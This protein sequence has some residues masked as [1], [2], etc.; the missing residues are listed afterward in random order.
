M[1]KISNHKEG[2]SHLEALEGDV[3]ESK[4]NTDLTKTKF[5]WNYSINLEDG[6][7]ELIKENF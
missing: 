4:A 6:L 5:N 1:I 7:K 2:I 3:N